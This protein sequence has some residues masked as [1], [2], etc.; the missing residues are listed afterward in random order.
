[1]DT[2]ASVEL[3]S[4][5]SSPRR[6]R[7]SREDP[8]SGNSSSEQDDSGTEWIPQGQSYPLNSKRLRIVHLQRIAESMELPASGTA[9]VT[10]QLIEGKLMEMG[11]EPRNAQVVIQS[12]NSAIYLR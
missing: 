3:A 6:E 5:D 2:A 1:M 12:E 11:K 7:E 9:A 4:E 8:Q 10:R